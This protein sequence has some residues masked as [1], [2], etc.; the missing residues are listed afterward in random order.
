MTITIYCDSVGDITVGTKCHTSYTER[1][2]LVVDVQPNMRDDDGVYGTCY[3]VRWN[4]VNVNSWVF[5]SDITTWRQDVF[6]F[7]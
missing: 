3:I 5:K 7:A 1:D 6:K 4:G 2:G